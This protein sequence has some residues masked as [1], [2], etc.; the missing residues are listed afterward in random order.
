[1]PLRVAVGGP[2]ANSGQGRAKTSRDDTDIEHMSFHPM[3]RELYE[4]ICGMVNAK[5]V[6]DLTCN[7]MQLAF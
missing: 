7:D 2:S 4:D 5:V 1:M 3:P 6:L